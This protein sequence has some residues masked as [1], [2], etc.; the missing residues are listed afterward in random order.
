[1][2][3]NSK[4]ILYLEES[5]FDNNFRLISKIKKNTGKPYFSRRTVVFVQGNYCGYCSKMKPTFQKVADKL[6][7]ENIDF[8][9][10]CID[11]KNPKEKIF[12]TDVLTKIIGENLNGVP[13]ILIFDNGHVTKKQYGL[14]NENELMT[15]IYT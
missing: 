8:A 15:F 7:D 6:N 10:I 5:E 11:S 4:N 1:M 12:Q 14:M 2:E 3:F 13:L 9:T